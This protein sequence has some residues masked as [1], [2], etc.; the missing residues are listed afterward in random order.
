ML[1]RV[2]K[3][4]TH[5]LHVSGS[6]ADLG[7]EAAPVLGSEALGKR[8]GD[9]GGEEPVRLDE[10]LDDLRDVLVG[11]L[12]PSLLQ[13]LDDEIIIELRLDEKFKDSKVGSGGDSI[14]GE[15][16]GEVG[17][18]HVYIIVLLCPI[19]NNDGANLV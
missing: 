3:S 16:G 14:L 7:V 1:F 9:E 8:A 6:A 10:V 5:K 4:R 11:L 15:D 18:C 13:K 12:N 19:V 17:I 2:R